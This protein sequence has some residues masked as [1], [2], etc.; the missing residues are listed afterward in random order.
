MSNKPVFFIF[1]VFSICICLTVLF[2][3]SG[4]AKD[5]VKELPSKDEE[6]NARVEARKKG[7]QDAK[8]PV[9]LIKT[10]KGDITIELFKNEAP[11][12]V[13]N[14]LGYVNAKFYDN[15]IFHRV[16]KDFMIQ[17]G[18]FTQDMTQKPALPPIKNEATNKI[19]N[20]KG[21]IAMAR[22]PIVDSASSQ[23]FIN[24]KDNP[25]LDHRDESQ[26]GYGY[27]VFGKVI[28][29]MQVVEKIGRLATTDKG[30]HKNV[31]AT[32]VIIESVR[33]L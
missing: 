1:I 29:G 16:I 11:I 9:V 30:H 25:S 31:P 19:L 27:C 2:V 15:T 12:T 33:L 8:N 14:F 5:E 22:P 26:Q 18:G 28:K 7:Q 10:S 20:A 24:L 3:S 21:T 6:I 32:P 23:F 17:G 4:K 13:N